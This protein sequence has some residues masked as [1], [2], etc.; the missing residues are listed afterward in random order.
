MVK[1]QRD[2]AV[3]GQFQYLSSLGSGKEYIT[4]L[5]QQ[6]KVSLNPLEKGE[7]QVFF[8]E[9]SVWQPID[10]VSDGSVRSAKTGSFAA[11]PDTIRQEL[12]D[13]STDAEIGIIRKSGLTKVFTTYELAQDG[14]ISGEQL[15]RTAARLMGA[16]DSNDTI[17]FLRGQGI[18]VPAYDS[19][20]PVSREKAYYVLAQVYAKQKNK[21]LANVK[22]TDFY[23]IEDQNQIDTKFSKDLLAAY[24][25]RL[26]TLKNGKLSPKASFTMNELRNF[27]RKL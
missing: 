4:E 18:T 3:Y 14:T 22:I 10:R 1:V 5:D 27:L 7:Y 20:Y 9:A 11:V 19:Y 16:G 23:A 2:F 8:R 17:A 13:I 21:P 6:M 26:L 15:I 12:A 25:L 24:H